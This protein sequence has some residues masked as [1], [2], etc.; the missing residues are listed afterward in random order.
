ML[1]AVKTVR[2]EY[3]GRTLTY[4]VRAFEHSDAVVSVVIFLC[5]NSSFYVKIKTLLK[6]IA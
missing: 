3:N 5:H 4:F 2:T 6:I 1:A